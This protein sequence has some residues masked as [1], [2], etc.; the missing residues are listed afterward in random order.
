MNE[1]TNT[2]KI[3]KELRVKKLSK[4]ELA[5]KTR[6]HFYLIDTYLDALLK[7]G[8]IIKETNES[9]KYAYYKLK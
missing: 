2:Q 6:I 8:K 3:L 5:F 4:S 1:D 7:G 9:G